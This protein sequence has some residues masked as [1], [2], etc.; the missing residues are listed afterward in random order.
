MNDL[1]R[2]ERGRERELE[3]GRRGEREKGS[4]RECMGGVETLNPLTPLFMFFFSSPWAWPSK[5][6]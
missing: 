1:K 3:R 4:E 5:L 6:G 2:R